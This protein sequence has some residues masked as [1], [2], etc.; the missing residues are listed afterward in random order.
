[1]A[2]SAAIEWDVRSGGSDNNGGGFKSGASG[3]DRSQQTAAHASGTNLTVDAV[4]NTDVAPDGYTPAAADVGNVIQITAGAGFTAGFY[5]IASI[6]SGKWRLDRSP[7]ATGTSGATW[8]IGG[9][10]ATPGKAGQAH[11]AGNTIWLKQATYT[12][13]SASSNVAGGCLTIAASTSTQQTILQGWD[14]NRT[15]GNTDTKPIIKADGVITSFTL[16]A[17]AGSGVHINNVEVDGNS[18]SSSRG[19]SFG[20]YNQV[21]RCNVKNCTNYGF[22][23][24]PTSVAILCYATGCSSASAFYDMSCIG[25]VAYA[26]TSHGFQAHSQAVTYSDCCS[27]SNTGASTCGFIADSFVEFIA[28]NCT[29]YGNGQHGFYFSSGNTGHNSAVNCLAVGNGAY[30]YTNSST[31]TNMTWL[32]SCAGY[33][34]T[35]GNVNATYIPTSRQQN[36]TALSADPFVSAAGLDFALNNTAGGGASLRASGWPGSAAAYQLPGLSTLSYRDI[37]A[38]Q[39]QDAGSN[40]FMVLEG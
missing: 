1:M 3:T 4:T 24:Q 16:V 2:L 26:N 9:A 19:I 6:Q 14:T 32:F 7:A 5:E 25:C 39:H 36:F 18:R 17:T 21:F 20:A 10:L 13:T 28:S 15:I 37:G 11:V 29:A 38:A 31:A 8:A 27:I 40:V 35:S 12:I 34:N 30:G 22:Y 33:N 23:A